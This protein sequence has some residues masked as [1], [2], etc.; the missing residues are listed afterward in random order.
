MIIH[1]ILSNDHTQTAIK[2][3]SSLKEAGESIN[4]ILQ[5]TNEENEDVK[6]LQQITFLIIK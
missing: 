1:M 4:E 2:E 3:V 6:T 5:N